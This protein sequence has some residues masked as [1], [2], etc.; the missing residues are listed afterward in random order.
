MRLIVAR[1][2]VSYAGRLSTVARRGGAA[3]D[4]QGRRHLHGVGRRRRPQREAAQLDGPADRDRGDAR[5]GRLAAAAHGA[6]AAPGGA[7]RHHDLGDPLRRRARARRRH[8][9]REGGTRARAAGAARRR[10]ALV[11]RGLSSRAARVAHRH[12][13][14]RP[15]VPRRRGRVDRGRDQAHRDDRRRRA[16]H[17]LPA[18]HP[19]R[20]RARHP[21][22]A[23]SRRSRSSRR[24]A[25]SRSRA[26][27]TASRSIPRSCAASASPSCACS[28][29][30]RCRPRDRLC[31]PRARSRR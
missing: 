1:C 21:V 25:C 11:R 22:A 24:R 5:R 26:A 9:A 8:R 14:G 16:A 29:P 30:E 20:S 4:G 13:P 12:R 7:A 6:Q 27:S 15:D 10:S 18:A 23:C 28:P 19:P 3:A 31:A 17:A 2:E